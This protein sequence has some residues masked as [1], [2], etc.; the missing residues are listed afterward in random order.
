MKKILT[1]K[2]AAMAYVLNKEMGYTMVKIAAL[3]DVSQPT[4]SNMI[5]DFTYQLRIRNLENELSEARYELQ[6]QLG[7]DSSYPKLNVID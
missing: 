5:K 6:M 4:I 3:M 7:V 2:H 1:D